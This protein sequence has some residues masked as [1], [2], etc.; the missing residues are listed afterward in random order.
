[1]ID[2][3]L[4]LPRYAEVFSTSTITGF[5][6]RPGEETVSIVSTAF[7]VDGS[8]DVLD[9]SLVSSSWPF[10]LRSDDSFDRRRIRSGS[11]YGFSV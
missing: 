4:Y 7:D 2:R 3:T 5:L 1:M 6:E 8:A 9:L 10:H 11:L